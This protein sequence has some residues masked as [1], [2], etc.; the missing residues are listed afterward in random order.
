MVARFYRVRKMECKERNIFSII[1]MLFREF[2]I[3]SPKTKFA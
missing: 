1:Q 2:L 3:I